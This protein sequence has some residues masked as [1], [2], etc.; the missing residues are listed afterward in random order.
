MRE[1]SSL[2]QHRPQKKRID[3][4]FRQKGPW[5]LKRIKRQSDLP[6]P[7]PKREYVS[8]ETY[9]YLGKQYRLQVLRDVAAERT[10]LYG[11]KLTLTLSANLAKSEVSTVAK[12]RLIAWYKER[13]RRVLVSRLHVWENKLGVTLT[14]VLIVEPKKRWG[15]ASA[16]G[17]LRLNWRVIQAPASLVDYVLLHELVH[18]LHKDHSRE[19]WATLGSVMPD[20]EERK[21]RLRELGPELVW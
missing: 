6:A 12:S 17:S 19:F 20:Y 11:G 7:L 10:R 9:L 13:A 18:L 5:I 1:S 8:G 2:R 14:K 15:S 4:I 21:K 3:E 16:D